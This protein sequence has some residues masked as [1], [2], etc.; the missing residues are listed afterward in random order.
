M[1]IDY[2]QYNYPTYPYAAE[3]I[4]AAGC[5]PCAV[6]DLIEIDPTVTADWMQ[7]HGYAYPYQGT[8]YSGI[9]ACLSAFGANGVMIA[10]NQDGQY[11]NEYFRKWRE[12]IQNGREGIL[13]M[14]K[15]YSSYWTFGGHYIAV[16]KYDNGM[17][18]VYDP[19]S[20]TRTGWHPFEDFAGDISALYLSSMRWDNEK[21]AIDGYWGKAT[22]RK[23]QSIFGTL[24]DGIVSNQN[25][26]M[27]KFL[28][29]CLSS[30][31]EFV[32]PERVKYG[33]SLIKAI[34]KKIGGIDCDGVFGAKTAKAFQRWLG[35]EAD[36]YIGRDT[37]TAFQKWLNN[38]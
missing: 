19:A 5:G 25:S 1:A 17:Y 24:R 31:W 9:N 37:V 22:T 4:A 6:A 26:S 18:L 3:T 34:Q 27:I 28:P 2:K 33:S 30:S 13:L 11:D 20:T 23:A 7:S 35:V 16:V 21:L 14:H 12:G 38:Q 8:A 36:G 29:R 15:V 10:Q 32:K